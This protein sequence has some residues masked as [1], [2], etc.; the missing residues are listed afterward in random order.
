MERVGEPESLSPALTGL[1]LGIALA[2]APGPVQAVLLA[3]AVRGGLARGLRAMVGANLTFGLLLVG[4][5]LGLSVA[6]PSGLVLRLL[7]V[8]GG[9]FLLW[10]AV[11][12]FRSAGEAQAAPD[13]RSRLPPAARGAL[14]VVLNPGAWLFLGIV[15]APLFASAAQRGGTGAALLV[16]VA[17]V[18][19]VAAGDV[20]VVVLGGLGLRQA[21][22]RLQC[23]IRRALALVLGA[24]ATWLLVSGLIGQGGGTL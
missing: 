7:G 6:A 4:L 16:A 3:E 2:S 17:L 1:G 13:A 19:G 12:G 20:T 9:S 8:A 23:W 5:A 22:A 11:D 14:A 18:A 10:L 21:S 24:L 15:A